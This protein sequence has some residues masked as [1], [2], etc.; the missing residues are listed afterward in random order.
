M[1]AVGCGNPMWRNTIVGFCT[2]DEQ[3]DA[4]CPSLQCI[5]I[6]L[7]KRPGGR[8]KLCNVLFTYELA[9]RLS[10]AVPAALPDDAAAA[11]R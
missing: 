2:S 7:P 8:S 4:S 6:S 11:A 1:A 5:S 9:R 10:A 3:F